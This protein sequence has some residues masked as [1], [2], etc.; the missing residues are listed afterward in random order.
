M[1]TKQRYF[2][3]NLLT[4]VDR[5]QINVVEVRRTE[6]D[7]TFKGSDGIWRYDRDGE[8]DNGRVTAA[9]TYPPHPKSIA[10]GSPLKNPRKVMNAMASIPRFDRVIKCQHGNRIVDVSKSLKLIAQ[11][12]DNIFE[13]LA[14]NQ[15]N[16]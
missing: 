11:E 4:T 12:L 8:C 1:I 2:V 16:L 13:N 9:S 7:G 14:P 15:W 6:Y 3:G 5:S 10:I